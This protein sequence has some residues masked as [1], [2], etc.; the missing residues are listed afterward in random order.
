VK[1]SLEH[2][3]MV[4]LLSR[5]R[6]GST[7]L[8]TI[9]NSHPN[10]IAPIESKFVLHLKSRYKNC[11]NW[12]NKLIN[13]FVDDLFTNR[14]IRL[15]WN[16]T[17]QEIKETL[18]THT[19]S[20]FPDACKAV[21]L[22]FPSSKTS[23]NIKIIIDK[24]PAHA[25]FIKELH[26]IFPDANFI[27]LIRDPRATIYS[28]IKAFN[29]KSITNLAFLWV[30]LNQNITK[31]IKILRLNSLKIKYENLVQKPEQEINSLMRFL[32]LEY[33]N[34]LLNS[35]KNITP[36]TKESNFYS[37]PH[38]R[39]TGNPINTKS[40]DKW[41]EN[42][43]ENDIKIINTIC[44]EFAL[45]NEYKLNKGRLSLIESTKYQ[46]SKIIMNFFR[47]SMK[48]FFNSPFWLRKFIYAIVSF[49]FDKK[50]IK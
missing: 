37:L 36:L 46:L 2:I 39:N 47:F 14:K 12:D 11:K 50:Y 49:F 40:L 7:L 19:I 43:T 27:H 38:H 6:S 3:Q 9:L 21:Y 31:N 16:V 10:I 13:Q 26:L 42:L 18:N 25:R 29:K 20:S 35:Y 23:Q 5:S 32:K 41:K 33:D 34:Q 45:E 15:F 44:C 8:Q 48:S 1:Q 22:S 30:K 24:N 28:Q 4:F 17:P